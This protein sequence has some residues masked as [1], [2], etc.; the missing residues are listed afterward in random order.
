[1]AELLPNNLGITMPER[2]RWHK[3]RS[4][5]LGLGRTTAALRPRAQRVGEQRR[6]HAFGR[7]RD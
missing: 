4:Q 1:M 2:I 3:G 7:T 5:Q 6:G